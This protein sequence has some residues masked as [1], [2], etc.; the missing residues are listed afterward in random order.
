M[1]LSARATSIAR[2]KVRFATITEPPPWARSWRAVSS[3]I[4][5]APSRSAL[6]STRRAKMPRGSSTAGGPIETGLSAVPGSRPM[7]LATEKHRGEAGSTD[8]HQPAERGL[9]A[10]VRERHPLAHL[11]R[12]GAVVEPDQ[13]DAALHRSER[14]PVFS[15]LKHVHAYQREDDHR[16]AR[17]G[18]RRRPAPAPA[19]AHPPL[20]EHHVDAPDDEREDNPRLLGPEP[21]PRRVRPHDPAHHA[22]GCPLV[23]H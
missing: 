10:P 2:S 21:F 1:A 18:E 5:P 4:M 6:L 12:R 15:E 23:R 8:R 7:G 9:E 14:L 17:D 16:E 3:P 13:D 20:E 11:D 19:G 22:E